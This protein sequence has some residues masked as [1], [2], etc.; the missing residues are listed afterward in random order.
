[1]WPE[2]RRARAGLVLVGLA[3]AVIFAFPIWFMVTSAF[4]AET[5]IQAI[6]IHWWPH[7][8]Q[9]LAR[10]QEA[11]DFA[12]LWRYLFNSTLYS[13][14][15]VVVTV[16]FGA[17]A[18]FGFAKYRFP[19]RTVLF[20]LVISTLMIPFQVL[21]VP[22][23]IE[24]KAFGWEN[25]YP[26]LVIPGMM[27]ALGVFMMRQYIADLPDELLE[28]GR[29]DGAG[30]FQ[31]FLGI[32]LPL[33]WPPLISLAIIEFIASWGNFLWPLVIVQDRN[34]NVLAV[35]LTNYSQPYQHAPMWGAAM[36]ASTIATIPIAALFIFF[37]RYFINGLTAGALKG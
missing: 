14:V 2:L 35:G 21:V 28:A 18:G 11:A 10:F 7:E 9:G 19:G 16:F 26:G 8:F 13:V 36:A 20:F 29:I 6:P 33:M 1:M 30:E 24:V 4:K 32:V 31:M 23:F 15:H 25:S 34:L 17:L 37:Q 5:E 27:N 12:P 22:L 3:A